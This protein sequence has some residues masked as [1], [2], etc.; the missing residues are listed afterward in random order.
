LCSL[1]SSKEQHKFLVGT[2][3]I[4][5]SNEIQLLEYVDSSNST[6]LIS[7]I[8]HSNE[9]YQLESSP[10]DESLVISSWFSKNNNFGAT[11]WKMPSINESYDD[12]QSNIDSNSQLG[13][14]GDFDTISTSMLTCKWHP[15]KDNVLIANNKVLSFWSVT[16]SDTK[17]V[18]DYKITL[19]SFPILF[20][21]KVYFIRDIRK[22]VKSKSLL[23]KIST[24]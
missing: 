22:V 6:R 23:M 9:I 21:S 24:K 17:V 11:L 16:E 4:H 20:I 3:S 15:I 2:C 10:H 1:K 7:T 13:N 19:L 14:A 18:K 8:A 5:D 12:F